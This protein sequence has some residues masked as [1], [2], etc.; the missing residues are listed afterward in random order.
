MCERQ[1]NSLQTLVKTVDDKKNLPLFLPTF[2]PN[3]FGTLVYDVWIIGKH[4]LVTFNQPKHAL[5][6][7]DLIAQNG[8]RKPEWMW[9]GSQFSGWVGTYVCYK[10]TKIKTENRGASGQTGFRP[11]LSISQPLYVSSLLFYASATALLYHSANY[12]VFNVWKNEFAC[13]LRF[14]K[15]N[16]P[17]FAVR[18]ALKTALV[19]PSGLRVRYCYGYN[20]ANYIDIHLR[21]NPSLNVCPLAHTFL[22]WEKF[23]DFLS[24]RIFFPFKVNGMLSSS[25]VRI[26]CLLIFLVICTPKSPSFTLLCLLL[27]VTMSPSSTEIS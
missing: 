17:I 1:K 8:G 3:F 27:S 2:S 25:T 11:N 15:R 12:H 21:Q 4:V 20:V 18:K 22:G 24:G 13:F 6:S 7:R 10:N 14:T 5:F 16:L 9:S 23:N 26:I 19:K